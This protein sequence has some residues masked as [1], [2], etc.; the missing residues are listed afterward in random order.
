MPAK[1]MPEAQKALAE[2]LRKRYGGA[3][4]LVDI[5]HELGVKKA[6][7]ARSFMGN[8]PAVRVNRRLKWR[9]CEVAKKIYEATE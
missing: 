5:A 7:T 2:E 8:A 6:E 4:T 9:V 3:M 1:R